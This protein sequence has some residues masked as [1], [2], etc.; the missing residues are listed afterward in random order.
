MGRDKARI[1]FRGRTLA[2]HVASVLDE[3]FSEVVLVS[4]TADDPRFPDWT[5]VVDRRPGAGPLAGLESALRHAEGRAVFLAACDLP[6]L[7]P[8][9]VR[10][11]VGPDRGLEDWLQE[12]LPA[13][14]AP[15]FEDR[16]QP[17]AAL[18]SPACLPMVSASLERG[19]RA[20]HRWLDTIP[21]TRLPLTP[22]LPFYRGDLLFNVND[23]GDLRALG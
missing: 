10:Y 21:V 7:S 11:V 15:V 16:L 2:E 18:Y 8:E 9:L 1:P 22:E 6:R 13:A 23:P 14:R 4:R 5:T 19:Q 12:A 17:L 20:M 3:V